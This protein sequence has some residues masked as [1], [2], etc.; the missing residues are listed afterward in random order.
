[1]VIARGYPFF[2]HF[3]F[4]VSESL[5]ICDPRPNCHAQGPDLIS[6]CR[7]SITEEAQVAGV[8]VWNLLQY[9]LDL[10]PLFLIKRRKTVVAV[11]AEL[12]CGFQFRENS[13]GLRM[14][15]LSPLV[16]SQ[17]LTRAV[18]LHSD[19]TRTA[20]SDEHSCSHQALKPL[21]WAF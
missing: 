19:K 14:C 4:Q 1:M 7:V 20:S 18:G 13:K 8:C 2:L 3:S 11:W 15:E 6:G 17:T 12:K 10:C 16:P 21:K 9:F 5:C